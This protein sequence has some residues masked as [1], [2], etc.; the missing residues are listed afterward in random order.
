MAIHRIT[1]DFLC[2]V[3]SDDTNEFQ[4]SLISGDSLGQNADGFVETL[5]DLPS[6]YSTHWLQVFEPTKP[7]EEIQTEF[8]VSGDN[9]LSS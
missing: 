8:A 9:L 7:I 1:G 6:D 3:L 2:I 4:N 5:L